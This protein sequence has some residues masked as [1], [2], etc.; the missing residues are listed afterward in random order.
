MTHKKFLQNFESYLGALVL[1]GQLIGQLG[2]V[3]MIGLG[4]L[5]PETALVTLAMGRRHLGSA[6]DYV[7][8]LVLDTH[9][10]QDTFHRFYHLKNDF[11]FFDFF[12]SS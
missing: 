2:A 10:T 11:I 8:A 6:E 3:L 7:L 1:A 9:V 5:E 12:K 4:G